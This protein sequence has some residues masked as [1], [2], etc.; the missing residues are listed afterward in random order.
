MVE[1]KIKS[2]FLFIFIFAFSSA[3]DAQSIVNSK[4]N[5]SVSGPGTVKASAEPE[6][7]IFCHTPHNSS[8]QKI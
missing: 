6:I 5:L 3:M 8:P 2:Y 1:V 4:H 7:C